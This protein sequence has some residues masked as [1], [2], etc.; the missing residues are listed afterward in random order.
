M[1]EI[2]LNFES[3]I[4]WAYSIEYH[5]LFYFLGMLNVFALRHEIAYFD[6]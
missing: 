4:F 6:G 5:R 3:V 2:D 1:S